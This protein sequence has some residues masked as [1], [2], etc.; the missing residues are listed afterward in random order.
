MIYIFLKLIFWAKENGYE[1]LS[2]GDASLYG[3]GGQG[4]PITEKAFKIIFDRFNSFYNFKG[5]YVF[6][7]KFDPIW[8]KRYLVYPS[9]AD[10]IPAM[11]ALIS[12]DSSKGLTK[13][14]LLES[15]KI[16]GR[17]NK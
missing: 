8:E 11:A 10:L 15:K 7:S 4:S 2:L 1:K 12:I 14:I 3:V 5:L 16:L 9:S 6:K 13:D 17:I